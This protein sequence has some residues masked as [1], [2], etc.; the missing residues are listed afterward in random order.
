MK[1]VYK[2][3]ILIMLS[4]TVSFANATMHLV[5]VQ[6]YSFNPASIAVTVGDTVK[7]IWISGVHTTTSTAIPLTADGWS[8]PIDQ[9]H[10]NYSYVITMPGDYFYQCNLHV[11]MGMTA[12]ISATVTGLSTV[13]NSSQVTILGNIIHNELKIKSQ[14]QPGSQ[15]NVRLVD[16][17]GRLVRN[18]ASASETT[19]TTQVYQVGDLQRG[20]YM[21]QLTAGDLNLTRRVILQ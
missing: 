17:T 3:L 2:A 12:L 21:V 14:L 9:N 1:K 20:L 10:A 18:F 11:S 19:G 16:L 15:L 13:N 6:D 4:L 7:W 8:Q 5:N